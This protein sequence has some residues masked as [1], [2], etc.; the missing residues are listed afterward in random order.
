LLNSSSICFRDI[1]LKHIG[2]TTLAFQSHV[3][4]SVT[5]PFDSPQAISY[6]WSFGTKPISLTVSEIFNG[7]CYAM[8]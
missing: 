1:G 3:T 2:V 6:W 7:E 4:S 5:R 8:I